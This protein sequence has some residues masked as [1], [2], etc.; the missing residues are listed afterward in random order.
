METERSAL[1]QQQGADSAL[2]M[3][4]ALRSIGEQSAYEL[5]TGCLSR[6][7][8]NQ[9][10]LA[11]YGG[12]APTH[13][14]SGGVAHDQGLSGSGNPRIRKLMIQLAG[15]RP[16]D[17]ALAR[18]ARRA[19]VLAPTPSPKQRHQ[20]RPSSPIRSSTH[21]QRDYQMSH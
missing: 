2:G 4:V 20:C 10:K 13:W 6:D 1:I 11:S 14:R 8:A 19:R 9:R 3:L 5:W 16:Q 12:L 21:R 18:P 15:R 7:Y 17:L